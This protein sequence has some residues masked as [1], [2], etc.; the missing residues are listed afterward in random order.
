[1]QLST[2]SVLENLIP[3]TIYFPVKYKLMGEVK[4][5]IMHNDTAG[6]IY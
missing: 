3:E 6:L 4:T 1:M 2:F 5:L